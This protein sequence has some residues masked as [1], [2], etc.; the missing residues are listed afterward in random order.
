[1]PDWNWIAERVGRSEAQIVA[2]AIRLGRLNVS[3]VLDLGFLGRDQRD[4]VAR[5][6]AGAG[7]APRLHVLDVDPGERWRRVEARN[8]RQGET[9]SLAVT[10]PMFDFVERLWQRPTPQEMAALDGRTRAA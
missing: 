5:G 4:R 1:M 2:M 6:V 10:R 7:L 9:F 8:A 3:S